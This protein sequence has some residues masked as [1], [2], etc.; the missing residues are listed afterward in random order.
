MEF[1]IWGNKTPNHSTSLVLKYQ[2]IARQIIPIHNIYQS[3]C[4]SNCATWENKGQSTP[5]SAAKNTTMWLNLQV[6]KSLCRTASIWAIAEAT[7]CLLLIL[8]QTS[9]CF[10]SRFLLLSQVPSIDHPLFIIS[11]HNF[12]T[13]CFFFLRSITSSWT[14]KYHINFSSKYHINYNLFAAQLDNLMLFV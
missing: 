11:L 10:H 9:Q 1:S 7:T 4:L 8:C 2:W 5:L 12:W 14:A 13:C 3:I 6:R